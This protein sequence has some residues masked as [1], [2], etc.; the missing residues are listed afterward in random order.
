MDTVRITR[1][2]YPGE[3]EKSWDLLEATG[4]HQ[5]SDVSP[6]SERGTFEKRNTQL[7]KL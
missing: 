6:L 7:Q 3:W 1:S 2:Y 4:N 5:K